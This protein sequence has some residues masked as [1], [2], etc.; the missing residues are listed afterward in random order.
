MDGKVN[1][2]TAGTTYYYWLRAV[3]HS[4]VNSAFV[5]VGGGN[6]TEITAS[7]TTG[8]STVDNIDRAQ[9]YIIQK[10]TTAAPTTAE[11]NAAIG[12]NFLAGDTCIVEKTSGDAASKAYKRNST[13]S[14]WTEISNL[15]SGDMVIDGTIGADQI[16]T[17]GLSADVI[18]TGTLAVARIPSTVVFT[19]ELDGTNGVT[20]ATIA[21]VVKANQLDGTN[22]VTQ[23]TISGGNI[24]TGTIDSC[25]ISATAITAGELNANILNLNGSTLTVTENG[26]QIGGAVPINLHAGSNSLGVAVGATGQ[27]NL[28]TTNWSSNTASSFNSPQ[29]LGGSPLTIT[30]AQTASAVTK[31]YLIFLSINAVGTDFGSSAIIAGIGYNTSSSYTSAGA[32]NSSPFFVN[33]AQTSFRNAYAN[34]V[35][36]ANTIAVGLNM[37]VTTSTSGTQTFYVYPWGGLYR[38]ANP[39]LQFSVQVIGLH[40]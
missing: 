4:D 31:S 38:I 21:G 10:S 29:L 30:V 26:L 28:T 14:S 33:N 13:N 36:G 20:Q 37:N 19:N 24:T 22:G 23:T 11:V 5:A 2:L 7:D 34:T 16:V 1:G 6:F 8:L 39:Q 9:F 15:I 12:R 40:R 32:M 27:H 25:T 3:N 17:S 18:S 35:S